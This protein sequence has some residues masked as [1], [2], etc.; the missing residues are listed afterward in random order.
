MLVLLAVLAIYVIPWLIL[1]KLVKS[2]QRLCFQHCKSYRDRHTR[3][4]FEVL[5]A[6][7]KL[8]DCDINLMNMA[9][10]LPDWYIYNHQGKTDLLKKYM[11]FCDRDFKLQHELFEDYK[12]FESR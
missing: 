4:R 2:T 5:S 3:Y 7:G 9:N 6:I 10:D 1:D 11:G 8:L 12:V